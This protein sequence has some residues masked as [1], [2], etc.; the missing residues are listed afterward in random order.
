MLVPALA[1]TGTVWF[2]QVRAV[3]AAHALR[4]RVTGQGAPKGAVAPTPT[5]E[6]L[7]TA[8]ALSKPSLVPGASAAASLPTTR[9]AFLLLLSVLALSLLHVW[10]EQ[11]E[12][13][14]P[15]GSW[16]I[17]ASPLLLLFGTVASSAVASI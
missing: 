17:V 12:E 3:A 6:G 14:V 8:V 15:G 2:I 5:Q 10:R 1:F 13:Q 9:R 4:R 7:Q 16:Y 11:M